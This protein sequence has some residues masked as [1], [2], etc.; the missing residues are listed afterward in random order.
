MHFIEFT[1]T[2][3]FSYEN[4]KLPIVSQ[5]KDAVKFPFDKARLTL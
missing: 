4:Q 2:R 3:R 5:K 1:F